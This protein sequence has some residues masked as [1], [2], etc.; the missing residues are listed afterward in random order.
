MPAARGPLVFV[1]W[2]YACGWSYL[3]WR[4]LVLLSAERPLRIRWRPLPLE[5]DE[6]T[7]EE[8]AELMARA[9]EL[10]LHISEAAK[11]RS[12]AEAL[13]AAL[14]AQDLGDEA[15]DRLHARLFRAVFVDGSALEDR[16][17]LLAVCESAGIDRVGLEGALEDGRYEPEIARA[18]E[19]AER[20]GITGTPTLLFGRF[21]L[22]GAAPLEEL[23]RAADLAEADGDPL[24]V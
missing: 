19:E 12:V 10:D 3:T 18:R 23:R 22:V 17:E 15:F 8:R 13:E 1:Y 7:A 6:P 21:K 24:G 5:A 9:A 4:G 2:D 20:Y 11:P 16:S 14:F